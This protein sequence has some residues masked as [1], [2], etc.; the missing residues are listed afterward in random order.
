M[1]HR[2]FGIARVRL[3]LPCFLCWRGARPG[4]LSFL[5]LCRPGVYA[6]LAI[7]KHPVTEYRHRAHRGQ[8]KRL[9]SFFYRSDIRTVPAENAFLSQ[10]DVFPHARAHI[11]RPSLAPQDALASAHA[12]G[13]PGPLISGKNENRGIQFFSQIF[14]P[15]MTNLFS[16]T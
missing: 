16:W 8:T 6:L 1:C 3:L 11:P 12:R 2:D 4:I 5:P 13:R 7:I 10:L 9:K 14:K 15:E